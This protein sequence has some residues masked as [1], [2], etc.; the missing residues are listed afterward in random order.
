[1]T[2]SV[3]VPAYTDASNR[4]VVMHGQFLGTDLRVWG[5]G[6]I[7]M[8]RI[9]ATHWTTTLTVPPGAYD[10]YAYYLDTGTDPIFYRYVE[11]DSNCVPAYYA[12]EV[13]P[14]PDSS[15]GDTVNDVVPNW[16]NS[17]TFNPPGPC[18]DFTASAAT[19]PHTEAGAGVLHWRVGN[20][21][22]IARGAC[23]LFNLRH[24]VR[25]DKVGQRLA[26]LWHERI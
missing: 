18:G 25:P 23:G 20:P 8:T 15:G 16:M 7:P 22:A 17:D 19:A 4:A 14:T 1:V 24:H 3:T 21:P 6:A 10:Y 5:D 11:A 12:R 13:V 26:V 2:F 9:D